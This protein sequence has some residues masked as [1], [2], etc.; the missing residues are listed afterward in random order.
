LDLFC[1]PDLWKSP[2][3]RGIREVKAAWLGPA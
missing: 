3:M 1:L 2:Q